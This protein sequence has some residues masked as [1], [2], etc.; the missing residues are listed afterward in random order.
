MIADELE[1]LKR[2]LDQ[3]AI[4]QEEFEKA[5]AAALGGSQSQS[6]S[7]SP[8]DVPINRFR[9]SE[10]DRWIGG[11]CGGLGKLTGVE[12]W[13]WRVGFVLAGLVWGT[14]LFLYVLLWIFVPRTA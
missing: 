13:V 5:K 14:G 2:L 7:P 10:S 11:V 1:K 8:A 9:L 4:T 12:S 6:S 3:G